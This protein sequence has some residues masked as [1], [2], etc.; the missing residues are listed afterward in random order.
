MKARDKLTL[1]PVDISGHSDLVK[2]L[3]DDVVYFHG[4]RRSEGGPADF[5]ID[6]QLMQEQV[7]GFYTRRHIAASMQLVV[8]VD[9]HHVFLHTHVPVRSSYMSTPR[10]QKST[11]LS[12]P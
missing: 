8:T 2:A 12:W 6:T 11:D 5:I 10:D 9:Y 4:V 3:E 7:R 1:S